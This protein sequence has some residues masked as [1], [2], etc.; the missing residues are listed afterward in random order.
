MPLALDAM[1][2][3]AATQRL[4]FLFNQLEMLQMSTLV[5]QWL[6]ARKMV[7]KGSL[8]CASPPMKGPSVQR[9]FSSR[10]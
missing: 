10:R 4:G 1:G 7:P 8:E 2:Q 5:Q 3:V 6:T 9:Y